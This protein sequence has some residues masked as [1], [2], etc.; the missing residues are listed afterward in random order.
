MRWVPFF[1]CACFALTLQSVVAPHVVIGGVRPDWLLVL[2]V[3]FALH[4]RLPDAAVGAWLIGAAADLMT[5]ERA[6]LISFSYLLVA[7]VVVSVREYL[8]RYRSVTQFLLTFG[9]AL[10]VQFGWLIYRYTLYSP[11]SS[12]TTSLLVDVLGGALYTAIWAPLIHR[13]FLAM[14]H[15]FGLQRPRYTYAGLGGLDKSGV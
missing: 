1:I 11:A 15:L 5:I 3:T 12:V 6:G 2:V 14:P 10:A 7:V 8:F 13:L 9:A 4:V